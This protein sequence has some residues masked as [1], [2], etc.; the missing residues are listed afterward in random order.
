MIS[1]RPAIISALRGYTWSGLRSD[2]AAGLTVGVIALP[3]AIGFAIASGVSPTQG[4]WTA[5]IAGFLISLLGGSRFQIGGPTGAF[6]PVLLAVV[7]TQG[8]AGLLAAT[9]LAGILLFLMG[10]TGFG[11]ALKYVPFPVVAGFTSG[12]AV[13]IFLA[14]LPPFL[15]IETGQHQHAPEM[16]AA[17]LQTLGEVSWAALG[18]GLISLAICLGG[19]K[20]LPRWPHALLAIVVTTILAGW[21]PWPVETLASKFG[22]LPSGLPSFEFPTFSL[23][24]LRDCAAPALTIALLGGI[25]SL[26]SATVADGMTDTRHNSNQEL[27]AQGIANMTV[28]FLGGFAATGAIARTAANI[29]AGARTPVAGIVHSAVLLVLAL[30]A[31]RL[32]GLIPLTAL[33]AVLMAVAIRM[34]EWDSFTEVW[35]TSR[36]DFGV[37][38]ATFL[39][40]VIFDLTAGVAG[41]LLMAAFLFVRNMESLTSVRPLTPDSDS[42]HSGALSLRGKE[43]PDGVVLFRLEGPLFFAAADRLEAALRSHSGRPKIIIFR[44]RHVPLMDVTGLKAL[45]VAVEKMHRDGVTV[46]IAGT[47]PQPMKIMMAS[48]LVQLLGLD[49]FCGSL[50]QALERSRQLLASPQT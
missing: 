50:D 5:I 15:G 42:E 27:M 9:F 47:Q 41:G 12:I 13:I 35:R 32:A 31:G 46:L 33:A 17:L 28:P 11:G 25:E 34:A 45:E 36:L 38:L 49:N 26:L 2:L 29:R 39:L 18:V 20:V 23:Q 30:A 48:G 24:M 21:L 43:V 40:T 37:L 19:P 22:E 10:L 44:M 4:L 14:Q 1:F 3:L 8:V 6:V 16:L 7:I